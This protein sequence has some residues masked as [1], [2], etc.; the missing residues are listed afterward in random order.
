MS[1]HT[2]NQTKKPHDI[3]ER[4]FLFACDVTRADAETAHPRPHR[5][6]ISLQL[7]AATVSAASNLEESDDEAFVQEATEL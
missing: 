7:V 3:R 6:G 2:T 5:R 4:T 1:Q